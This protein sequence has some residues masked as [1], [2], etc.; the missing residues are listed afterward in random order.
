MFEV[1]RGLEPAGGF[2]EGAAGVGL[3]L[4]AATEPGPATWDVLLLA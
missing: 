3:A 1:D 2:L 4:L